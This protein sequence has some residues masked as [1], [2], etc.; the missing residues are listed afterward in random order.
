MPEQ[1]PIIKFK[2]ISENAFEPKKGSEFAAGYDLRSANEYTIPPMEK[3]LVS[4]DLQIALPD[5]SKGDRIAQLICEKICYPTLQ[6]VDD[7]D[8]TGR[9]ESGFGSSGVN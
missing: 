5:V 7:L 2:R 6:E 8:Q 9:G 1:I 4:T 3:L